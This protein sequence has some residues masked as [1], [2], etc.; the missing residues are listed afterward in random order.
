MRAPPTD[1]QRNLPTMKPD[2]PHLESFLTLA[3]IAAILG[4]SALFTPPG[5]NLWISA[6]LAAIGVGV[7]D[8]LI[9]WV[10]NY[11]R[12]HDRY[13]TAADVARTRHR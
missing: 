3:G 11:R 5:G 12:R 9:L 4:A 13:L 7:A 10:I 2:L 6:F 8:V 1:W